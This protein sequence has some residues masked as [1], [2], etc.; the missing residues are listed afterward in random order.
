M[1]TPSGPVVVGFGCE[2]SGSRCGRQHPIPSHGTN[3]LRQ[4][5]AFDFVRP[6]HRQACTRDD[7]EWG[8]PA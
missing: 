4:R 5:Y 6:D 7:Y 3:L 2:A 8:Q 1:Y